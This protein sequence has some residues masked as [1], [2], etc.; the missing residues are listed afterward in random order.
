[1]DAPIAASASA[2]SFPS[3]LV[4]PLIHSKEVLPPLRCILFT[5]GLMRFAC[6]VYAKFESVMFSMFSHSALIA[7]LES[8]LM[9]SLHWLGAIVRALW[10]ASSS[11]VLLD[12]CMVRPTG[13]AVF[14]GSFGPNHTPSLFKESTTIDRVDVMIETT[15]V[16]YREC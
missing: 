7:H 16:S 1:M 2:P 12:C 11:G 9:C 4:C 13:A 6:E 3:I 10:I 5:I 15:H 14:R 8:V